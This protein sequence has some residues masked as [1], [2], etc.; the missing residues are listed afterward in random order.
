[1][2]STASTFGGWA[3]RFGVEAEDGLRASRE[4]VEVAMPDY[5]RRGAPL[6][7]CHGEMQIGRVLAHEV[8]DAGLRIEFEV[9]DSGL[10]WLIRRGHLRALSMG[11]AFNRMRDIVDGSLVGLDLKE[12]SLGPTPACPGCWIDSINS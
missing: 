11:F 7:L 4:A 12:F 6:H 10:C 8:N 9:V 5:V 1:M 3:V 2:S